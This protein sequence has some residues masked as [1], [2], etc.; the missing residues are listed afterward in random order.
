M[1]ITQFIHAH[2]RPSH[3][4]FWSFRCKSRAGNTGRC[5]L[6]FFLCHSGICSRMLV[7]HTTLDGNFGVAEGTRPGFIYSAWEVNIINFVNLQGGACMNYTTCRVKVRGQSSRHGGSG[8]PPR[9][10]LQTAELLLHFR[11]WLYIIQSEILWQDSMC[12]K[13]EIVALLM[14]YIG[15]HG[16]LK[17]HE[18]VT[19][20]YLT[21]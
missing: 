13:T 4:A 1:F 21:K 20:I 6:F 12:L 19:Q 8:I 5:D 7:T 16:V 14:Y 11:V 2:L 10:C 3:S 17:K 9:F 18:Y 15:I